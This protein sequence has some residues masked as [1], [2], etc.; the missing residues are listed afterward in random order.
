MLTVI[1]RVS[2]ASVTVENKIIGQINQGLVVLLGVKE[3]DTEQQIDHLTN[4]L[5][6]LRIF[7]DENGKMNKSLQD[8]N[9]QV[10]VVSQF[11]LYG[12]CDKGRRPSFEHSEEPERAKE[13]YNIFVQRLKDNNIVVQTGEFGA[14]MQVEIHNDGPVTFILEK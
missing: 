13:L 10:L 5:I 9:G 6:N 2:K 12:N 4:K 11:T 8:I 7:A 1:Q 14:M 3:G